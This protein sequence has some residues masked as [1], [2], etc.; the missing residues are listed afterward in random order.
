MSWLPGTTGHS[1]FILNLFEHLVPQFQRFCVQKNG[2]GK[3][4]NNRYF[5]G[6]VSM[7]NNKLSK[8]G[9]KENENAESALDMNPFV[10]RE[11]T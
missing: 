7:L 11:K 9:V 4:L 5:C 10:K 8:R 3:N 1:T 2:C 6:A